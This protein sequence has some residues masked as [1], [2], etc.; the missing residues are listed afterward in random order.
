[1]LDKLNHYLNCCQ[2]F[3]QSNE[4]AVILLSSINFSKISAQNL[5][6]VKNAIVTSERNHY[7]IN[8]FHII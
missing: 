5:R 2:F 1:M 6:P 7:W 8:D 3:G 4:L